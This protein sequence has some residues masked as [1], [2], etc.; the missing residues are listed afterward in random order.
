MASSPTR[1]RRTPKV[2]RWMD[3]IA[4]LLRYH[5][6]VP[7]DTLADEVPAYRRTSQSPAARER[8]FARD[9]DELRALGVP[10]ESVANEDGVPDRYRLRARDF[11]LPYLSLVDEPA[12]SRRPVTPPRRPSGY[13]Y[14]GLPVLA[15]LPDEL[16]LVVRAGQRAQQLGDPLLARDASAALRKLAHDLVIDT[17]PSGEHIAVPTI[18]PVHQLDLLDDAVR[19]RKRITFRYHSIGR[20]VVSARSVQPFGLVFLASAWYLV[21]RDEGDDR[22]KQFRLQRMQQVDVNAARPQS[23]DFTVPDSFVLSRYAEANHPWELGDSDLVDALVRF[24]HPR[25]ATHDAMAMGSPVDDRPDMRRYPVRRLDAFA[26]WLLSHGG[27]AVPEAPPQLVQAYG[28]LLQR[29]K[30]IYAEGVEPSE[31]A[32]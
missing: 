6:P 25:G 9:K 27:D 20:D 5:Y 15:F 26:R 28:V 2:Q 31:T 23:P 13:G 17:A 8:M 12:P 24:E 22:I 18:D 16:A 19:Q 3:L 21:G 1:A 14:Q 29:T 4:A 11:Y 32:Q 10:I 7:F 30:A